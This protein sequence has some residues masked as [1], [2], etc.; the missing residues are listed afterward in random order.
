MIH[1]AAPLFAAD[2]F[3]RLAMVVLFF[4]CLASATWSF[5]QPFGDFFRARMQWKYADAGPVVVDNVE[6]YAMRITRFAGMLSSVATVGVGLIGLG[7]LCYWNLLPSMTRFGPRLIWAGFAALAAV[8]VF[9]LVGAAGL[10]EARALRR[11][12]EEEAHIAGTR[13]RSATTE[14]EDRR[15]E[16]APPVTVTGPM[17]FRAGGYDWNV[18]DFYKNVAIFGQTGTGKTVCVLNAL[19]DGLLGQPQPPARRPL[20]SSSTP[21]VTFATRSAGWRPSTGA[22]ETW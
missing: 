19:F 16:T 7:V 22:R 5:S 2:G 9:A 20:R 14:L 12:F 17:T 21:R 18:T 1:V 13:L 6:R 10:R 15:A 8:P 4:G 3:L 11:Q